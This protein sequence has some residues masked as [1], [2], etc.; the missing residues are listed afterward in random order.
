M[1]YKM[2]GFLKGMILRWRLTEVANNRL[3]G[4]GQIPGALICNFSGQR[5]VT[6]LT[7]RH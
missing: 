5:W 4:C 7:E 1:L 3:R 6:I 2:K